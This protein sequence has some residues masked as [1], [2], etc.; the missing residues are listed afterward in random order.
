MQLKQLQGKNNVVL[1]NIDHAYDWYGTKA[2]YDLAVQNGIIQPSW[3]CYITDDNDT[4]TTI[5]NTLF[6]NR[7]DVTNDTI[8][9]IDDVST[10]IDVLTGSR[11]YIF[12][13]S[14]LSI[15]NN[16]VIT[17]DFII[18]TSASIYSVNFTSNNSVS[19]L[20]NVS[21]TINSANTNYLFT[22]KSY[23]NGVSW[24]GFIQGYW[25]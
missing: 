3:T 8:V 21:P 20:N 15:G 6:T 9:L 13:T 25:K 1:S 16:K 7:T 22:F 5:P 10:Y 11:I 17:F 19:W 4:I 18:K 14:K 12:D 24:V 23:D 2:E